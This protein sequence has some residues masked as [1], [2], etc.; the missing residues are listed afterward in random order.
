[1]PNKNWSLVQKL[2]KW[3]AGLWFF[4]RLVSL[5]APYFASVNP[6]FLELQPGYARAKLRKRRSVTN[7]LGTVHAIAMANLCEFVGGTLMEISISPGMR[8][9]PRGMTIRYLDLAKSDLVAEC[10]IEEYDWHDRQDV[11]LQLAVT[12]VNGKRV[13][14]AEIPMYVS[15]RRDT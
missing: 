5:K 7:H 14:E 13:S 11:I 3:P 12:D 8:W 2:Q 10:R 1:M 6:T 4:S 15:P 9:I